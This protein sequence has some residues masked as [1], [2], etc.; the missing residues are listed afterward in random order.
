[1]VRRRSVCFS[2]DYDT[3]EGKQRALYSQF[4]NS[5]ARRVFPGWDEPNYKATFTLDVTVPSAQLAVSNMPV[6]S[7]TDLGNGLAHIKFAP[8]PKMSTY[9][10]FLSVGDF[11]RATVMA[12][13]TEI[14][15]VTKRGNCVVTWFFSCAFTFTF[16]CTF[17]CETFS[18][19]AYAVGAA[20]TE[21]VIPLIRLKIAK[22]IRLGF[23]FK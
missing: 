6:V 16:V 5:D 19:G 2:L 22:E 3:A 9:L 12:D 18:A 20:C 7:K 11:E 1:M 15:V 23:I 10:L 8:S 21:K 14:G 4:E 17:D 13:G